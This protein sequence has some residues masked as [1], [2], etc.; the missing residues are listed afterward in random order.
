[1]TDTVIDNGENIL[2]SA[3]TM[4]R[5]AREAMG[6][7]QH[8]VAQELFLTPAYIQLIDADEMDKIAKQAFVRGYLR[9]YAKMVNLDADL[10]VASF[11][12]TCTKAPEVIKMRGVTEE[13]VGSIKFTGPVIQ[14]GVIA[15]VGLIIIVAL[16]WFFTSEDEAA[17]VVVEPVAETAIDA[18]P[19]VTDDFAAF[20]AA[21]D[22]PAIEQLISESSEA[23]ITD[24][25]GPLTLATEEI[26]DQVQDQP[27]AIEQDINESS[28]PVEEATITPDET[29]PGVNVAASEV[30]ASA[31]KNISIRRINGTKTVDA[32]GDDELRFEFTDDCWVEIED[33]DGV[34]IY[35]DLNRANDELVVYGVAPFEV[36]FGKAPAASMVFNGTKIDLARHTT[37]VDTAKVKVGN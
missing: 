5:E 1:M 36:L 37:S 7:T 12:Q 6:L 23:T 27:I 24:A 13:S 21:N 28:V 16:V 8:D 11:D 15:L 19:A 32:G 18:D 10:V 33:A 34:S 29:T 2:P 9:S 17:P 4:L 14:T 30:T 31:E 25:A 26:A 3:A 35:G 20:Q 22:Q